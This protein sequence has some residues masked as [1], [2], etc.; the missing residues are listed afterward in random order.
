MAANEELVPLFV[1][2][3]L[4]EQKAKETCK[5]EALSLVLKQ[6]I[7][8]ARRYTCDGEI[9]KDAGKLLYNLSTKIKSKIRNHLPLLSECVATGRLTTDLQLDAALVYL[10]SNPTDPID[11]AQFHEASGVGVRY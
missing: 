2:I 9:S 1:S 3:G 4:S 8:F 6:S 10:L 5:N 11:V 7:E